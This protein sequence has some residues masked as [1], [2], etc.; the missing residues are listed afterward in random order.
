[1]FPF[2]EQSGL[3]VS[4]RFNVHTELKMEQK[5]VIE[6]ELGELQYIFLNVL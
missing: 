6:K 4:N 3:N 2:D 1:M 5:E